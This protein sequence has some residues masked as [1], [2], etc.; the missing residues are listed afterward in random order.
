M[1]DPPAV[2]LRLAHGS[3]LWV[4]Q[5]EIAILN[6]RPY[7]PVTRNR[8][9]RSSGVPRVTQVMNRLHHSDCVAPRA[10]PPNQDAI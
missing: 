1:A 6:L 7:S 9:I 8:A 4:G 5:V 3:V 10:R 2:K